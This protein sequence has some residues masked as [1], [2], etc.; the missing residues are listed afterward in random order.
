MECLWTC[1]LRMCI[2]LGSRVMCY[3]R[4]GLAA[5]SVMVWMRVGSLRLV[6]KILRKRT[7]W[8][9]A[10]LPIS[11]VDFDAC[12]RQYPSA[13]APQ[14]QAQPLIIPFTNTMQV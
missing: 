7:W 1:M 4:S 12:I 6:M 2:G 13:L 3:K 14:R 8:D 10:S 9:D 11:L 5:M